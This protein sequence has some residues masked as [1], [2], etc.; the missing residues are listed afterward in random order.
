[1]AS[2]LS[3]KDQN[4]SHRGKFQWLSFDQGKGNLVPVRGELELSKFELTE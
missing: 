2:E 4:S 1:M 3:Y